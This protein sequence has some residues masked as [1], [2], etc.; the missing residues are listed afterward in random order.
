MAIHD[1]SLIKFL[2]GNFN[3][4]PIMNFIQDWESEI[5][6]QFGLQTKP[7]ENWCYYSK[8]R[9]FKKKTI[10][11]KNVLQASRNPVTKR[12]TYGTK[13]VI[14]NLA[15]KCY[16]EFHIRSHEDLELV[17][18]AAPIL[19][20][21]RVILQWHYVRLNI[22]FWDRKKFMNENNFLLRVM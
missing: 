19:L 21:S 14:H 2:I 7:S 1:T 8:M 16:H 13:V 3:G 5:V 20:L 4:V 6:N 18:L 22:E 11:L 17:T 10:S 15:I 9:T 12:K